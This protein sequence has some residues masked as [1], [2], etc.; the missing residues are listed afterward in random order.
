MVAILETVGLV[1]RFG[2]NTVAN[3]IDLAI[4][5]GEVRCII[6][7]NG[8]GKST[9]L[10]LIVGLQA[11]SAGHIY[12]DGDDISNLPSHKRMAKGLAIKFQVPGIFAELTARENI[13]VAIQRATPS[14]MLERETERLLSLLGL[15][16]KSDE[17][18]MNLS[19]GQQQWL[20][21]GMA[22]GARPK[23]LLLDEPTAGMSPEETYKTG[24][25]VQSLNASGVTILAIEHDMAFVRQV[26]RKITVLHQGRVLREG[27]ISEIERDDEVARIYFGGDW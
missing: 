26:A 15:E 24:E 16:A 17:L 7:P 23:V 25:L 6:G 11:P 13:A 8:A 4:E 3:S 10:S 21:I 22:S 2:G 14:A 19:H 20:E 12:L 5:A 27:S 18:A 1:K 9:L